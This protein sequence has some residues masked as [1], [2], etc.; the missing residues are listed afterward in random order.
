LSGSR[1][2]SRASLVKRKILDETTSSSS[3]DDL[4]SK[5]F[6]IDPDYTPRKYVEAKEEIEIMKVSIKRISDLNLRHQE[7]ILLLEDEKDKLQSDF[8]KF[9]GMDRILK[10]K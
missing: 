1:T 2:S 9:K 5:K 8:D 4:K 3:D 6:K 10:V 7:K